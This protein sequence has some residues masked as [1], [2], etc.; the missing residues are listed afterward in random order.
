MARIT[1]AGAASGVFE[2]LFGSREYY[3]TSTP[4]AGILLSGQ[5]EFLNP[6]TWKPHNIYMTTPQLYSVIN[7]R[8]YL[9][10]SGTWKHYKSNGGKPVEV[11][12]SEVVRLLEN[13]NPLMKGNDLIRQWN[14]NICVF[15]NNYEFELKGF[16]TDPI[17]MGLSNIMPTTVGMK[18]TGKYYRQLDLA[19]IIEYYEVFD[20]A[21]V[22]DRIETRIMNH[23]KSI[24]ALNPVKGESMMTP[25]HMPISNIRAA[26]EFRNVIMTKKGAL[27]ILSN[28]AKD[29]SG[30]IPLNKDERERIE[31]EY[32]RQY[33]IG[34]NQL[35]MIM[36]NASLNWQAMTYPT[37]D[38]MLFEEVDADFRVIIDHY[39]LNDNLFSREKGSTFTNLAEGLK[40]AYQSTIIPIGKELAMNRSER[41]KL[42]EKGEWL[43]LDYGKIPVLQE[44][45]KEKAETL[46]KKANA[47]VKLKETG[48]YTSD[49]LKKLISF[50]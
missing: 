18:T 7:R 27:G 47:I 25:I 41:F 49:E 42:L 23:T 22:A 30:A 2:S 8:G 40:Q 11:L 1:F 46:E 16:D 29:A 21:L 19:S 36:T 17:P 38:L 3:K 37:K 20:G 48:Y 14:E 24:N 34:K 26:Y 39:G 45:L 15:G 44:N 32:Q 13:P 35:Q 28:G 9:L 12:N 4:N 50:E 31:R 5:P 6:E 33:G 43:E 10:A